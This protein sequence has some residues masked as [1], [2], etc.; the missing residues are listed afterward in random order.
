MTMLENLHKKL[1]RIGANKMYNDNMTSLQKVAE[2]LLRLS[3]EHIYDEQEEDN[4]D[5]GYSVF[6]ME[7]WDEEYNNVREILT[8]ESKFSE[9]RQ[10]AIL[11][12]FMKEHNITKEEIQ[13]HFDKRDKIFNKG[14][15]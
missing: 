6:M 15:V 9:Y 4:G 8:K 3:E 2:A 12:A 5:G 14:I 7:E 13:K 1:A 10:Q 11:K